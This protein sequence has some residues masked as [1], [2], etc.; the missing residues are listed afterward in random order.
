MRYLL[1]IL[2]TVATVHGQTYFS[3]TNN[4]ND[5]NPSR[6]AVSANAGTLNILAYINDGAEAYDFTGVTNVD[7]LVVHQ[8]NQW[9][10]IMQAARVTNSPGV[11]RWVTTTSLAAG[12]YRMQSYAKA[13][14]ET[15]TLIFDRYLTVTS[16]LSAGGGGGSVTLISTT[17]VVVGESPWEIASNGSLVPKSVSRNIEPRADNTESIGDATNQYTKIYAVDVLVDNISIPPVPKATPNGETLILQFD[18]VTTQYFWGGIGY[19]VPA[20]IGTNIYTYTNLYAA[21]N[22][23]THIASSTQMAVYAWGGAG[24]GANGVPGGAGGYVYALLSTV[25]GTVY[26]IVV[27]NGGRYGTSV[28]SALLGGSPGGG[29]TYYGADSA[30][31]AS[32]Y[33]SAGGYSGVMSYGTTNPI[34]IA[35]GG[36]GAGG[37]VAGRNGGGQSGQDGAVSGTNVVAGRGAYAMNFYGLNAVAGTNNS[38]IGSGN[39]LLGGDAQTNAFGANASGCLTGGGAGILGGA[40]G[41]VTNTSRNGIAI[42]GGGLSYANPTN[43]TFA[44]SIRSTT[45]GSAPAQDVPYYVSG[46]AGSSANAAG[47]PGLV[48]IV[49]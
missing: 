41:G 46:R 23:L 37:N 34:V 6:D 10:N 25:P 33:G 21:G 1:A 29:R 7:L 36:S 20:F 14:D 16:A 39:Y 22:P 38:G 8:A 15:S 35:A 5:L 13:V 49:E 17:S 3:L 45:T 48:V 27:A 44:Y 24:G 28:N 12:N 47:Q 30:F 18:S 42:G 2:L 19:P 26:E 11:I 40:A 43:V 9:T 31:V 4:I 32:L